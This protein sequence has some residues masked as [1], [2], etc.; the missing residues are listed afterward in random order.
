MT[1]NENFRDIIIKSPRIFIIGVAGDS[2]SGK[3]TFTNSVR[4]I[5][6]DDIVSTITLDDYHTFDR[7]ERKKRNITPLAPEA[8]NLSLL[9][10]HVAN[11][12]DGITIKKPVYNHK[13]GMFDPP[14]PY[15]PSEIIILEGLHTFFTS[16]LR[17]LIDFTIFVNPD[18]NVKYNWK[19]NRD[20]M[21]RGYKKEDVLAELKSRD[22]D[23]KNFVEPQAKH[24]NAVIEISDSAYGK[25][26]QNARNV[27]KV[28]LYQEKIDETIQNISLNFNLFAI[29][30]LSDRNFC[31]GF[32]HTNKY[33]RKSGALFL[34]GEFQYDV[35]RYLEKGIEDQ[36][37]MRPLSLFAEKRYVNAT[38]LIAL[39]LAW[40]I[41]NKRISSSPDEF[42]ARYC[43][44]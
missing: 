40:R 29:N 36:I 26:V 32:K 25:R 18:K 19:I 23:Y 14:V 27:Y 9:E 12:K 10:E 21:D 43:R 22:A 2:G 24:A 34:D 38:D 11:L 17:E 28:T 41:I 3:T 8:N 42:N 1:G 16:R 37:K 15:A 13:T 35:V 33:G 39:L 30:S 44:I 20:V 5:F 4:K 6:G 7:E 31:M